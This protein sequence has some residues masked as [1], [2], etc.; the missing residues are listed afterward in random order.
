MEQLISVEI[1]G[2]FKSVLQHLLPI[3][4]TE[5]HFSQLLESLVS[6][7]MSGADA[8]NALGKAFVDV[9]KTMSWMTGSGQQVVNLGVGFPVQVSLYATVLIY[10]H[11]EVHVVERL[12]TLKVT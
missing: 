9:R 4:S 6:V 7:L 3:S 11:A 5:Q 2:S 8:D 12:A 1:I 10:P